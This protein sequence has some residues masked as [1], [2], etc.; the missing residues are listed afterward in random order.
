M[1][2]LVMLAGGVVIGA[3]GVTSGGVGVGFSVF[4]C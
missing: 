1:V 3:G 4:I 2:W